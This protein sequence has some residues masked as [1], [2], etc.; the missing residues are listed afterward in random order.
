MNEESSGRSS[1]EGDQTKINTN[2]LISDD[3]TVVLMIIVYM[4]LKLQLYHGTRPE[5]EYYC[6]QFGLFVVS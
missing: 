5:T 3:N 6:A 4:L 1:A 2:T